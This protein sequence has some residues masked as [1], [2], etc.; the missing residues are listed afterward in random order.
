MVEGIEDLR[1]RVRIVLETPKGFDPHR[2]EF[3]SNIWQWLDRPF[4][5]AMPNVIAEA[6]EAIERWI[7]DFKVSQ[8]KV[9]E[10]NENGRFFFSIR[11]IWNG[12][13]VEVE[14]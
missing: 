1:Q 14:V 6:Y 7:T 5:E 13:A 4:T 9:E 11:G 10:A 12:E 2:P 8:I 3:G